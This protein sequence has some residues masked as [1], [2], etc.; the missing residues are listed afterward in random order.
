MALKVLQPDER[1]SVEDLKSIRDS[2]KPH[3]VIDVRNPLEFEICH[4]EGSVNIPLKQILED[5]GLDDLKQR[6]SGGIPG[7]TVLNVF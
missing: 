2:R 6:T 7:K 4:I 5:K 3:L 1:I